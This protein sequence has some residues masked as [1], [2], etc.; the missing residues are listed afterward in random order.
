MGGMLLIPYGCPN[1]G[2]VVQGSFDEKTMSAEGECY[3][4]VVCTACLRIHLVNPKTRKVL[5]PPAPN[6]TVH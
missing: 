4:A 1:T 2:R 6:T 5:P 3:E